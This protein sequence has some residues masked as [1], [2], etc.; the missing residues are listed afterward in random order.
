MF[1]SN[2][3]NIL[4]YDQKMTKKQYATYMIFTDKQ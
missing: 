4:V 1:F 3:K 2:F